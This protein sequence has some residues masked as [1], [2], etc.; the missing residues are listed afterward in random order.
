[1]KLNGLGLTNVQIP[2]VRVVSETEVIDLVHIYLPSAKTNRSKLEVEM[3]VCCSQ[4]LRPPFFCSNTSKGRKSKIS[5]GPAAAK[6][7]CKQG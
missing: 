2:N 6:A 5:D 4:S 1:V 3:S 7:K